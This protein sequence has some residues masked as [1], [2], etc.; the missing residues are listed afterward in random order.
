[1]QFRL[2]ISGN[3]DEDSENLN[4]LSKVTW[5]SSIQVSYEIQ[6]FQSLLFS[7]YEQW[8]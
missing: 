6:A 3:G 7:L 2:F 1:M 4:K 8:I 5:P